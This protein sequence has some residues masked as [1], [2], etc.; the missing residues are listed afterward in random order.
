MNHLPIPNLTQP[1][2]G[3][4]TVDPVSGAWRFTTNT[5]DHR[6]LSIDGQTTGQWDEQTPAAA[7]ADPTPNS[8]RLASRTIELCPVA[9]S[10]RKVPCV[11]GAPLPG[12]QGVLEARLVCFWNGAGCA[13]V[14]SVVHVDALNTEG[15]T[16]TLTVFPPNEAAHSVLLGKTGPIVKAAAGSGVLLLSYAGPTSATVALTPT[17]QE[18]WRAAH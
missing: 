1:I 5:G 9:G 15:S 16:M 18:Q 13:D 14:V 6:S 17:G 12:A 10:T 2:S 11:G 4:P 8:L 3:S 7:P